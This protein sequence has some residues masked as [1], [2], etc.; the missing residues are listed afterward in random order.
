MTLFCPASEDE[1]AAIVREARGL[2]RPFRLEG[3][4]TRAGLGGP[5]DAH[6]VL[7]SAALVGITLHEPA[8]LV[9]WGP[10]RALGG[11]H[12]EVRRG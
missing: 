9:V 10:R 12:P 5:V 6:D 4:G 8:E 1:A 7:R 3:G 11:R 2:W